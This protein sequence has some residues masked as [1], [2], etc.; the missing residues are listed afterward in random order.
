MKGTELPWSLDYLCF[1]KLYDAGELKTMS[2]V[3]L[4]EGKI[5]S[6]EEVEFTLTLEDFQNSLVRLG[7]T[8]ESE[9]SRRFT[10]ALHRSRETG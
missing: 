8:M 5:F 9:I 7:I 6:L 4:I 1:M 3:E 10:G 2:L